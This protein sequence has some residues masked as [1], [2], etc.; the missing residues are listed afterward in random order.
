MG[1][2]GLFIW[3]FHEIFVV[4]LPIL[5]SAPAQSTRATPLAARTNGGTHRILVVD[6]NV[7]SA[8]TLGALL[9]RW[10]HEVRVEH[11]G[12]AVRN[13]AKEFRP[14][15]LILDIGLPGLD[16]YQ[17]ARRMRRQPRYCKAAFI[18]LSGYASD[19]DVR[20]AMAAGFDRHFSK[21]TD[22]DAIRAALAQARPVQPAR[23]G[24][25]K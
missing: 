16:G 8:H 17:I 22:A 23:K 18:A 2:E 15:V 4:H 11:D 6:D 7:D 14:D 10:G 13:A 5:S 9:H 19:D 12:R 3:R 20:Q 25:V 1:R 21:P 24:K